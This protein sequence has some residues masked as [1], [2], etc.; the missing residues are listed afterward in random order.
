MSRI[1]SQILTTT[2]EL[3]IHRFVAESEIL[4]LS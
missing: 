4:F 1:G 2:W 3:R